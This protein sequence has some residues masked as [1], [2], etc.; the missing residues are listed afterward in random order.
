MEFLSDLFSMDGVVLFV[1]CLLG[2]MSVVDTL[3]LSVRVA[4]VFTKRLAIAL[5]LFNILMLFSR[6]SNL[7]QAPFVGS[8]VD[9]AIA[10]SPEGHAELI[11]EPKFRMLILA[12]TLGA[13]LGAFL[14]PTFQRVFENVINDFDKRKSAFRAVLKIINPLNALKFSPPGKRHFHAYHDWSSIPKQMLFWNLFVTTFYTIGVLSSLLAGAMHPEH[15]ATCA[16]LSGLVNGIATALLFGLVDPAAA[17]ITDHCINGQ[18]P[19]VDIKIMNFY[20]IWTKIIGTLLAQ[21]FL[22][23]MAKYVG[24]AAVMV[25]KLS[26]RWSVQF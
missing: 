12:Y 13:M 20:L 15:R 23:P 5:S 4:G 2:F 25:Q 10:A 1:F 22:V 26:E 11:V 8:M 3:N 24:W 17:I 21:A 14:T 9:G 18:R 19:Q 6:S 16:M 7:L